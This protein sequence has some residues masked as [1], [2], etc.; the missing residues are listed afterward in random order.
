MDSIA[1]YTERAGD[2]IDV[3]KPRCDWCYLQDAAVVKTGGA[4]A[5]VV[6]AGRCLVGQLAALK[7]PDR[8]GPAVVV[9]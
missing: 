6:I 8:L 3:V 5:F 9:Y 7:D 2:A 4:Q 1:T